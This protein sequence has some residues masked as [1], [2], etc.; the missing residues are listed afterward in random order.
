M[1]SENHRSLLPK[2]LV[3]TLIR[4]WTDNLGVLYLPGI[5]H[6][7][8]WSG[9]EGVIVSRELELLLA[10]MVYGVCLLCL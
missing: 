3:Q 6:A 2:I 4:F 1:I 10:I 7:T 8:A 5:S 9:R